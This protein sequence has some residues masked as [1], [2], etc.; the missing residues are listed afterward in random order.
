MF[1]IQCLFFNN[2]LLN[3]IFMYVFLLY[4]IYVRRITFV[5]RQLTRKRV[6]L[7]FALV[8]KSRTFDVPVVNWSFFFSH[9][10]KNLAMLLIVKLNNKKKNDVT[11]K[12]KN[13]QLQEKNSWRIIDLYKNDAV[14]LQLTVGFVLLVNLLQDEIQS[15]VIPHNWTFIEYLNQRE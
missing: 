7:S 1:A 10:E 14:C 2:K 3:V 5:S 12:K 11:S 4:N 9:F 13:L 8:I 6:I 15:S